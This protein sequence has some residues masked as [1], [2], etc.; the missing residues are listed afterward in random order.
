MDKEQ[1]IP[2]LQQQEKELEKKRSGKGLEEHFKLFNDLLK[3]KQASYTKAIIM[4][5]V[6]FIH[7]IM[8]QIRQYKNVI[9]LHYKSESTILDQIIDS[10]T[11]FDIQGLLRQDITI[12]YIMLSIFLL[13]TIGNTLL[14]LILYILQSDDYRVR[15]KFIG[16]KF[17]QLSEW[18]IW[19]FHY[20]A[21][22]VFFENIVC[23]PSLDCSMSSERK[24]LIVISSLGVFFGIFNIFFLS[25]F[26]H[27]DSSQKK[28]CFNTENSLYLAMF[29]IFRA[30]Q[31]FLIS[32]SSNEYSY[33]WVMMICIFL[34]Y[35]FFL[36]NCLFY[37]GYMAFATS[38]T[39]NTFLVLLIIMVSS[40]FSMMIDEL[41]RYNTVEKQFENF[42]L[43]F[44]LSFIFLVCCFIYNLRN[45]NYEDIDYERAS[46]TD[47]S[48]QVFIVNSLLEVTNQDINVDLYF[49]GILQRHMEQECRHTI[50]QGEGRC[51]CKKK[52][53]FDS[54]KK[55]E[56]MLDDW[57]IYKNIF[58][59][60]LIKSWIETKLMDNPNSIELQLLYARFMFFK[61]QNHQIS[62]HILN[63]LEKR[64]LFVINRYKAYQLKMKI[65]R[66]IKHRNQ[67]SYREKLEIQNALF[68][69]DLIETIKQ[70]INH[71]M[72]QNCAFWKCLQKEVIDLQELDE[73][74][75]SQFEK[76]EQTNNLWVQI[77]NYLDF[78]KKWKFYY[79]WF[80][81]YIQ[82][83]KLK[84]K[85][86]DNF[87]GLSV[88]ENDIFSEEVQENNLEEDIASVKSDQEQKL[89]MDKIDIKS[90]KIIFDKKACIIQTTDDPD[91]LIIKVNKQFTKIFGYTNEEISNKFQI[92]QLMPD[93]YSKVHPS[94][95]NDYKLTGRGHSLYSQRKVYCIHKSGYMFTAQ[96]FLKLYIDLNGQSQFVVMIRPTDL[97]NE[98]KHDVII[99]NQDWEIN[100]MTPN[101]IQ[102]LQIDQSL[103]QKQK[104]Q[105]LI[106]ILLF[107]PKLIQFSRACQLINEET[108]LE[109]FG[110]QKIKKKKDEPLGKSIKRVNNIPGQFK[111][112]V[113]MTNSGSNNLIPGKSTNALH[114]D[115][116]LS[117]NYLQMQSLDVPDD[118]KQFLQQTSNVSEKNDVQD[119]KH[120]I[121]Q[122]SEMQKDINEQQNKKVDEQ[123][124]KMYETQFQSNYKRIQTKFD[125]N[126]HASGGGD[127]SD[128]NMSKDEIIKQKG[129]FVLDGKVNNGEPISFHMK[130]SDKFLAACKH[131]TESKYKLY[132]IKKQQDD[133]VKQ[134]EKQD[135]EREKDKGK[136]KVNDKKLFV[137]QGTQ[138]REFK[139]RARL[140]FQKAAERRKNDEDRGYYDLIKEIYQDILKDQQKVKSFKI[141]CTISFYKIRDERIGIMKVSNISEIL[142]NKIRQN[143][144]KQSYMILNKGL[145]REMSRLK[146]IQN[147]DGAK[148]LTMTSD[149]E[150]KIVSPHQPQSSPTNSNVKIKVASKSNG[151]GYQL[152][153]EDNL[154][155]QEEKDALVDFKGQPKMINWETFQ[156]QF[157][158]Q[159]GTQSF[160]LNVLDNIFRKEDNNKPRKLL[161]KISYLTWFL[162]FMYVTILTLNLI[163]YF[164]KPYSDFLPIKTQSARILQLSQ[165]QTYI[166]EAYDT[167]MDIL[168]YK[169]ADFQNLLVEGVALDT[170]DKFFTYQ[171]LQI[172]QGYEYLKL[173][174]RDLN[175]QETF[176]DES[177]FHSNSITDQTITQIQ[178]VPIILDYKDVFT[179]I[180]LVEHQVSILTSD[181]LIK[182]NESNSLVKYMRNVTVPT[183]YLEFNNAVMILEDILI[184][185]ASSM[186][187][188]VII[189][190]ILESCIFIIGFF[191]LLLIILWICQTFKAVL[192]M[193]IMIKKNDLNKIVKQQQFVQTQFQYILNKDD[194]ISGILQLNDKKL[195]IN[196]KT[197]FQQQQNFLLINEVEDQNLTKR[198]DKQILEKQLLK[199]LTIKMSLIYILYVL[200]SS[201]ASLV[202]FL[203][204]SNSSQQITL[205]ITTGADSIQDF[206]D[207]QLLLVSV[208]EK[209]FNPDQYNQNCLQ[210]IQT[211]LEEQITDIKST[212]SIE[213]PNYGTY[214]TSFQSI[215]FGNLCQYLQENSYLS[216]IAA[217]DCQTILNGKLK[218]GVV[219]F[220]QLYSSV[221]EDYVLNK[222]SR[223]G[224]I[225]LET[226]WQ[227]NVAIDY[228][229]SAFKALLTSWSND[230]GDLI[231]QYFTLILVLLIVMVVFQLLVFITIAEMY[232]VNQLN[233]SF[234]FYRK[235]Y[236]SYMPNDII[237]KE[238]IIRASLIKYSII[239]R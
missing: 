116:D 178:N 222:E 177:I 86:L 83:K 49:K 150:S 197:N 59:K 223:F 75:K 39:R 68:I 118:N 80:T 92:T 76:I 162:R 47:F 21:L 35:S 81:L 167:V 158:M 182:L 66:Y 23:G 55:K 31:A 203:T 184:N 225:N 148:F 70:N 152:Q 142:K 141:I 173:Q 10:G 22:V 41:Y 101:V 19:I 3:L 143:V 231:D 183:L 191:G 117:S 219:A 193:F 95:L 44:T 234:Q 38:I 102:S 111:I 115:V 138:Q 209:Y 192:K 121:D 79:A 140:M 232:L 189:I 14:Y 133:H 155:D 221:T 69:E 181:E 32:F 159:Q 71:I 216:Q 125:N 214:Y 58:V 226:I 122:Y 56:V 94:L 113:N 146:S 110:M 145:S 153:K 220:N 139:K 239:K 205:L 52:K 105:T 157:K 227:Y 60:F 98:K 217:E 163:T 238:K 13:A 190:L 151:L 50:I 206:S 194:E 136:S 46:D 144:R 135:K 65:I 30:F 4:L 99:L 187:D 236:K 61:F 119:F 77:Q 126:A 166:I 108:D 40:S 120:Q 51:F 91:A 7:H 6:A 18:Y 89:D 218:Q 9:N 36:L 62:L 114:S 63:G 211:I 57:L 109:L 127:A 229:K 186:S 87:Q 37:S 228:V 212:P 237:Q 204:L 195:Q 200:F 33:L 161:V 156:N 154:E 53:T 93:I 213:D 26:F 96:K 67:E 29:H 25:V 103:F 112:Q 160:S 84:N 34:G 16:K 208:K 107:A 27:N 123:I 164:L 207:S 8:S 2:T 5:I 48:R 202:F 42:S 100:G 174:I 1:V 170:Q 82:N 45:S 64:F 43:F 180:I 137:K 165:M 90:K 11:Y 210:Q 132:Q 185:K 78:K 24:I 199:K 88:N 131:Y 106:N 201:S 176:L 235:I 224:Q 15:K 130:L 149:G 97:N 172:D 20:P 129:Q 169:N 175:L 179:K 73:L 72:I 188:F 74:L 12:N 128:D 168:L 198:K 54:K 124:K 230:L 147:N 171:T 196:T 104:I 28:D 17:V 215:Y 134:E 85:I 233:K